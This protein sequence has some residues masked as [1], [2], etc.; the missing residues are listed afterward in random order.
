MS[1]LFA[2]VLRYEIEYPHRHSTF[3]RYY[4]FAHLLS[5]KW[6]EWQGGKRDLQGQSGKFLSIRLDPPKFNVAQDSLT[7]P[8]HH[9]SS[10]IDHF[11]YDPILVIAI[12]S[13]LNR[14]SFIIVHLQYTQTPDFLH[15]H[16]S[17]GDYL[18]SR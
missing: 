18:S 13:S 6:S 1:S 2:I 8:H 14:H 16:M 9:E 15:D 7:S 12:P 10:S 5:A 4:S 3:E 17:C 11:Q